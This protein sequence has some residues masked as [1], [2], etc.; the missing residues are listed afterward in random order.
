MLAES[1][2]HDDTCEESCC[3]DKT[4][5]LKQTRNTMKEFFPNDSAVSAHVQP[6]IS[7]AMQFSRKSEPLR[8]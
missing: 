3:L 4:I 7:D 5:P 1:H 6:I 2:E 8:H